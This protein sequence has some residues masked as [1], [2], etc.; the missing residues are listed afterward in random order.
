MRQD[1]QWIADNIAR[2][3]ALEAA[4]YPSAWSQAG[5]KPTPEPR[6]PLDYVHVSDCLKAAACP[7]HNTCNAYFTCIKAWWSRT[8][9][10]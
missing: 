7:H 2:G 5:Y 1:P 8:Q 6:N 9:E 3:K 4:A 10:Q